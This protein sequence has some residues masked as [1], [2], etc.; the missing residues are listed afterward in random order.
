VKI[1]QNTLSIL[2]KPHSASQKSARWLKSV[3][4]RNTVHKKPILL[5]YKIICSRDQIFEELFVNQIVH[6]E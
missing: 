5:T 3:N 2:R 6:G 4:K 1:R